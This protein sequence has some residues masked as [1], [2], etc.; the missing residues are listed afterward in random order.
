[1]AQL[2]HNIDETLQF[3]LQPVIDAF[4]EELNHVSDHPGWRDESAIM[5]SGVRYRNSSV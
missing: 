4:E 2:H 3:E 1:M 5:M